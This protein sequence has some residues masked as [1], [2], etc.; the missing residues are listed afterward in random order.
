[1]K[2]NDPRNR[3]LKRIRSEAAELLGIKTGA[4]LENWL[5][6]LIKHGSAQ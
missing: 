1:M 2:K 3:E 6:Q 4:P 5:K